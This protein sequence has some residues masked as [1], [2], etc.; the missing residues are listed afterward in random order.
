MLT[1]FKAMCCGSNR[2]EKGDMNPPN[3]YGYEG[4]K[5]EIRIRLLQTFTEVENRMNLHQIPVVQMTEQV[6]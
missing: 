1:K 6:C 3:P 4:K 2:D 5:K